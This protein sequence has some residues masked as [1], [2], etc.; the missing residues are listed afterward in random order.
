[1]WTSSLKKWT[2]QA[3][4]NKICK[5][6]H[7]TVI[8]LGINVKCEITGRNAHEWII[9]TKNKLLLL[10]FD[11]G[12]DTISKHAK[13]LAENNTDLFVLFAKRLQVQQELRKHRRQGAHAHTVVGTPRVGSQR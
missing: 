1:M 12:R 3:R 8:Y 10:L 13:F 11:H 7:N 4:L 5:R 6:I 2:F 9:K